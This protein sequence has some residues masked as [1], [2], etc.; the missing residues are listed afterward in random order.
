MGPPR[1]REPEY[2]PDS[3]IEIMKPFAF[4]AALA[5][6]VASIVLSS[7]AV[8]MGA[9]GSKEVTIDGVGAAV[10]VKTVGEVLHDK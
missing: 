3:I 7:C 2:N 8:K 9:D 4:L 6:V 5:A 1:T 10:A